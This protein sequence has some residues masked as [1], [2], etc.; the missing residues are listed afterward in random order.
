MLIEC[1]IPRPVPKKKAMEK[2]LKI[3]SEEVALV[4]IW[5]ISKEV[6][7]RGRWTEAI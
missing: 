4:T 6:V 2:I 3:L 5:E 1:V 7:L